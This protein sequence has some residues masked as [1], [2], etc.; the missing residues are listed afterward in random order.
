MA[1]VSVGEIH[2]ISSRNRARHNKCAL[3]ARM[4]RPDD[5]GYVRLLAGVVD[6]RF[7]LCDYVIKGHPV[8]PPGFEI[9]RESAG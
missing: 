1:Y 6:P 3:E 9:R 5:P 4:R 8:T 2:C 7:P